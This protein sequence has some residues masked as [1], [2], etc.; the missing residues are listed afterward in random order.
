M[1]NIMRDPSREKLIIY[2]AHDTTLAN[3]L[4]ALRLTSASCIWNSYKTG[5]KEADC[6]NDY[7]IY[8]SNLIFE[9]HSEE[10]SGDYDVKVT[11]FVT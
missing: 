11:K 5:T 1:R 8:S 4:A 2:S 7:P 6:I 3:I 10:A 9:L